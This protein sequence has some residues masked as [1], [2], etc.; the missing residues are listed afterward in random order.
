MFR[1][2]WR[3]YTIFW[4][5]HYK[6]FGSESLPLGSIF[7]H[8][9]EW[10]VFKEEPFQSTAS[11]AMDV[12]H[13]QLALSLLSPHTVRADDRGRRLT[14]NSLV[15]NMTI[16]NKISLIPI[17]CFTSVSY[18]DP[19]IT[20][21]SSLKRHRLTHTHTH[22]LTHSHAVGSSQRRETNANSANTEAW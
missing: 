7:Q 3:K 10:L 22:R 9:S 18:W 1:N 13:K 11:V 2:Y 21:K 17:K 12:T 15:F 14:A 20:N 16:E 6:N 4:F 19:L 8:V 5:M